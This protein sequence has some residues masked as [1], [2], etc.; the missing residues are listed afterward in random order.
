MRYMRS[1]P[2]KWQ[3]VQLDAAPRG[4]LLIYSLTRPHPR[5]CP[6]TWSQSPPR[7]RQDKGT[8]EFQS[9]CDFWRLECPCYS[10]EAEP[11][12]NP[13]LSA[14][15]IPKN[16]KASRKEIHRL[17]KPLW[18][19]LNKMYGNSNLV[20]W[21]SQLSSRENHPTEFLSPHILWST[22]HSERFRIQVPRQSKLPH[23]AA[24]SYSWTP[25]VAA[26][27]PPKLK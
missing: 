3:V 12:S 23:V 5:R 10:L 11:T 16:Q 17:R 27:W 18:A 14:Q 13:E 24:L 25:L 20:G 26:V 6:Q 9:V 22:A 21:F 19:V 1:H 8:S 15:V 2:K 7:P 4:G